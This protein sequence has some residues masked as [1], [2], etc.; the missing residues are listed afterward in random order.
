LK[1]FI[2]KS[3]SEISGKT[4]YPEL[5]EAGGLISAINLEFEK[6]NLTL[7]AKADESYDKLPVTYARVEHG[8]KFSQV[9]IA[10]NEQLYLPDFWRD[11]VCL[12]NASTNSISDLAQ[13]ISYWLTE[14]VSARIL[15]KKFKFVILS[16]NADSFDAN[17][18]V[19][20]RWKCLLLDSDNLGLNEFIEVASNNELISKLF[21]FTS[22]YTLCF[23]KCTGYPFD[24]SDLPN[25][26]PLEYIHFVLPKNTAEYAKVNVGASISEN[27]VYVVTKNKTQYL[28][29]GTA[30][31]ALKIVR[32]NLPD[33]IQPARNGTAD[34]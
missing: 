30:E 25:V 26:T 23:S 19:E 4:L 22:L 27:Q 8:N 32:N 20:Y 18:G 13:V 14:D 24:T 28:G 7:A 3:R 5:E 17:K 10:A 34:D 9:Y 21:P 16:G 2:D 31:D 11:G 1:N 29:K 12:A 6:L 15:A 33:D